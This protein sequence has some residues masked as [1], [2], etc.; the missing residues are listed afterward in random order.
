MNM[1]SAM[2][3]STD[4]LPVKKSYESP[5]ITPQGRVEEL[6]KLISASLS[7]QGWGGGYNPWKTPGD[8]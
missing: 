8:S 4:G 5:T 3:E 1:Q 2:N 6:T 7:P